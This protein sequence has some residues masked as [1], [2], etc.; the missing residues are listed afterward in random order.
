MKNSYTLKNSV[1]H[2]LWSLLQLFLE[3]LFVRLI[4]IYLLLLVF[5]I[6]DEPDLFSLKKNAYQ[7]F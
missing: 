2:Q 7:K 6:K 4:Y 5:L 3:T 1:F